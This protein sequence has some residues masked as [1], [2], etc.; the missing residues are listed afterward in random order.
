[1]VIQSNREVATKHRLQFYILVKEDRLQGLWKEEGKQ[2]EEAG[3]RKFCSKGIEMKPSS[4]TENS[5]PHRLLCVH[6]HACVCAYRDFK[7]PGRITQR[8]RV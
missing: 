5:M 4:N 3:E 6:I 8:S 7:K 1:M 2:D